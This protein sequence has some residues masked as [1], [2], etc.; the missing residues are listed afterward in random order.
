MKR[1]TSVWMLLPP[2]KVITTNR[3]GIRRTRG[4]RDQA[5]DFKS[6]GLKM[7]FDGQRFDRDRSVPR[8]YPPD[9]WA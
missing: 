6:G 7:R 8:V 9:S 3:S 2:A 4:A 1:P 5:V